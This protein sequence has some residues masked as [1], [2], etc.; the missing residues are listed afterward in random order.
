MSALHPLG[1][2]QGSAHV[3]ARVAMVGASALAAVLDRLQ[4]A[5]REL[6]PTTWWASNGRDVLLRL[7][8][9]FLFVSTSSERARAFRDAM[10]AGSAAWGFSV[11]P[12][13]TRA[14]LGDVDGDDDW[15]PWCGVLLDARTLQVRANYDKTVASARAVGVGARAAK[16]GDPALSLR[17]TLSVKCQPLF[18]DPALSSRAG[19]AASW[20][21]WRR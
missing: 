18:L 7:V 8:D 2:L 11:N 19:V 17:A 5:W 13:K 4:L 1:E 3:A 6:E 12:S 15:V 21:G 16:G 20:S 10:H 9:D 14:A